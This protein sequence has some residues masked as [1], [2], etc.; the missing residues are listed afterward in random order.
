[1]WI[2]KYLPLYAPEVEAG[3]E[4]PEVTPPLNER[5]SDGPGSG[6]GALRQQLESAFEQDRKT[7]VEETPVRRTRTK[8]PGRVAGGAEIVPDEGTEGSLAAGEEG[9]EQPVVQALP[10]PDGFTKEAKAEWANVPPTVQAAVVKREQDM[11]KGVDELKRRQADLDQALQPRMDLI[12]RHGHTPAQAV[13]QLFAWFEALSA[14]PKVA[15]PALADSF[16]FDL[17]QLMSQQAAPAPAATA[18]K[19][20]GEQPEAVTPA[21]QQYITGLEQKLEGFARAVS[22]QFGNLQS[23]F[24]Q[25]SEAKTQEILNSWSK[26]KPHFEKVRVAMAHMLSSGMVQ[27]LAD[28]SADLDSAYDMAL[29][30]LPD[31]RNQILTEQQEKAE[32]ERQAK[33]DKEAKAQQEQAT[34]ARKAS[35]SLSF[36]A[37]GATA[38]PQGKRPGKGKSVRESLAE[39]IEASRS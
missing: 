17:K 13:N 36:S 6:R 33:A 39:A 15:F 4:A 1:M 31:V 23:T 35:G 24:Q 14:N 20:E 16:K 2:K 21:V 22:Q 28:G 34:K 38:A 27:P 8:A 11:A 29:Y 32:A 25:Q 9:T 7:E 12:R 19:P 37:P 3:V 30:A 26:D 18:P 10:P 5:P